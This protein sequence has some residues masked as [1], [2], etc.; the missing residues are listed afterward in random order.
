M[1]Q[2]VGFVGIGNMG[3]PMSANI[4]K[5][6]FSLVLFDG[7]A[8]VAERH[9]SAIGAIAADTLA[10]LGA[11][12][13]IVVTMLPTGKIVR[14]VLLADSGGL[15]AA[16]KPGALLIDMSSSDPVG[17]RELGVLLTG[18]GITFVDAPVSGAV[19]RARNGTLTIMLGSD[20]PAFAERAKPVL[21]SMGDRIFEVGGLGAGHAT[22]ALNNFVAAAG[23]AA[24]AEAVILSKRFGL[25]PATLIEVMNVSTGRN[26]ST[27]NVFPS[28]VLEE[29]FA[30]GFA[31]GLLAKDVKIADDL[32]A[33][34]GGDLPIVRQTS[35]W[36]SKA[37]EALGAGVDHSAAIRA[38]DKP[39]ARSKPS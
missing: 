6:G 17:T 23:Y 14:D 4:A 9:A 34:L 15:A 31:L 32:A 20:D 18:S 10:E 8:G 36:W 21:R 3:A 29:E 24:A 7:V 38:W 25:D 37:N 1:M 16:L 26:F 39:P 5:A 22:K 19:P 2:R 28:H 33:T 35:L 30:T 13:D 12:S 11:E 27:E